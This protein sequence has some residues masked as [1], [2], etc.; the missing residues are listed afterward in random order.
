MTNTEES[1]LAG[2][3]QRRLPCKA[4]IMITII[5]RLVQFRG[6]QIRYLKKK[7]K[8]NNPI[9]VWRSQLI[10]SINESSACHVTFSSADDA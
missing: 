8:K 9:E 2:R 5:Y 10:S 3:L 7:T 6:K 1:R 4:G